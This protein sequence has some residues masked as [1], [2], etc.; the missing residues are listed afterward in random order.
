[1]RAGP[2]AAKGAAQVEQEPAG[3]WI[4]NRDEYL[5]RLD[6]MVYGSSRAQG[7][8]RDNRFYH[9]DMGITM[10][11][12]RG[13]TVENQRDRICSPTRAKDS[14]MQITVEACQAQNKARASSC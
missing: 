9:A 7:I 5:R 10:A 3:G 1:M 6:G 12:P 11:F 4:D 8:V 13:W 2:G 14:V